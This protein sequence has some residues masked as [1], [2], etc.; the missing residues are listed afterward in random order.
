MQ[1]NLKKIE[2]NRPAVIV[3]GYLTNPKH[4]SKWMTF[5]KKE[6]AEPFPLCT[7]TTYKSTT[8]GKTWDSYHV[9]GLELGRLLELVSED[10]NYHAR[11]TIT[12][13]GAKSCVLE[14]REWVD[15]GWLELPLEDEM[16]MLMKQNLEK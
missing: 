1:E 10:K 4:T 9:V 14:L 3:F 5:I 13:K 6:K 11:Y 2:I 16:M 15:N 8:D 12:E 7:E